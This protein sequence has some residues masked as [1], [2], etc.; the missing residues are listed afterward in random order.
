MIKLYSLNE[1]NSNSSEAL[2]K[3]V[4][5]LDKYGLADDNVF[6]LDDYE[7]VFE[8]AQNSLAAGDFV[9]IAA[10]KSDYLRFKY[11]FIAKCLLEEETSVKLSEL[12]SASFVDSEKI[13]LDAHCAMPKGAK[14]HYSSDGLY[15]GFS[16]ELINGLCTVIPLD[17]GRLDNI[18]LSYMGTYFDPDLIVEEPMPEIVPNQEELYNPESANLNIKES[19]SKMIYSLIQVDKTIAVAN[20]E[21][22]L[23]IYNLYDQIQGLSEVMSFV[24][25]ID[26][27]EESLPELPETTDYAP[28]AGEPHYEPVLDEDGNQVYD[29]EGEPVFEAIYPEKSEPEKQ[30]RE[31]RQAEPKETAS[32][33]TIRH[34]REAMR[35]MNSGFGAAISEI[36][37]ATDENG[38]ASYFVFVAIGDGKTIKAKRIRTAVEAEAPELIFHAINVLCESVCQK[39]DAIN[40]AKAKSEEEKKKAEEE[41]KNDEKKINPALIAVTAIVFIVAIVA[42][43]LLAHS[44]TKPEPTTASTAPIITDSTLPT[45]ESSTLPQPTSDNL[46]PV[47]PSASDV[48]APSTTSTTPSTS[49]TFTFYVFGYG[50]GVGLSQ[51]GANYY[52]KQG[53]TYSQILANYY[54]G[55][56]LMSGDTYP[57]T[58]NY[59]GTAYKTR[60]FIAGALEGEMGGSY[61][62]EAL[63][64]QAVAIYTFAKYY[65]Y[66]L[67]AASMAYKPTPSSGCYTAAD[68]VMNNGLYIAY[69]GVPA[70]TPFHAM[71]AGITTS[72]YN[73]WGGT[74]LA[75]LAGGRPSYGDYEQQDFKST[76]TLTSSE[77]KSIIE[78][79]D[80]SVSLSGDPSTWLSILSHDAAVN[81]EVGYV[82]TIR[83]GG[84]EYSGND[85]RTKLMGNRLRSHCFTFIYTPD[86]AS[87]TQSGTTGN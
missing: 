27:E 63:R 73:V 85:F 65:N 1:I 29:D 51:T 32:E 38:E 52:A 36:Y 23:H 50:H 79:S 69:G 19:V 74:A 13:E 67:D 44:L 46:V 83:V 21:A 40:I 72:Y 55:T 7:T 25:I 56:T 41:A 30:Q 68:Y 16:V 6:Q 8:E 54:Y 49:G 39:I 11:E 17:F 18:L 84:K 33:K 3:I 57:E 20:S 22:A 87:N 34:A 15:S 26:P 80:S 28:K 9:I 78:S 47:E 31:Q 4:L 45:E 12:I 10:E 71:S 66:N 81:E 86:T 42:A 60:D 64:A 5:E 62:T 82:S 58:I 70:L 37:S 48:S 2:Y 35:N 75:Y 77:L 61:S 24:E 43:V 53:W 76:V 14:I 59:A